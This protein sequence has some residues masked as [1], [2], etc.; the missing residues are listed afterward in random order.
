M[1]MKK[2]VKPNELESALLFCDDYPSNSA[3]AK[4]F[5][6]M[7]LG[8]ARN[9]YRHIRKLK[10]ANKQECEQAIVALEAEEERLKTAITVKPV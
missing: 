9:F 8:S 3:R 7:G 2:L 6:Q 10:L 4:A 1:I 5:E